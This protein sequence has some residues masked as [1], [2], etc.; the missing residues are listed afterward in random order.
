MN[1]AAPQT[2]APARVLLYSHDRTTR[3]QVRLA[4]GRRVAA[5]LP[6][7]EVVEVATPPLVVSTVER[8]G[9]DVVILDGEATPEGGMGISRQLKDEVPDAPPVLLLVARRDDAWL[10]TW[11][12]A[13][14]VLTHPADPVK[15]PQAVAELLRSRLGKQ[16]PGS[17]VA[18]S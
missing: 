2:Q 15:L 16:Q 1:A 18:T 17:Q 4:M 10:A 12:R 13:E 11:S 3:Q 9:I 7:I 8:G 6:E 5:D 14:L